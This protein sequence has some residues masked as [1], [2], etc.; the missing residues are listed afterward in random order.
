LIAEKW[1]GPLR[2]PQIQTEGKLAAGL[3]SDWH[4][5]DLMRGRLIH[6]TQA[7]PIDLPW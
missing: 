5:M 3:A 6:G 4:A 1:A 2:H 7:V